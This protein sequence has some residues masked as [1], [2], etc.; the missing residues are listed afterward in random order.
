MTE[1]TLVR[2][3]EAQ[4]REKARTT[5]VEAVGVPELKLPPF[6]GTVE[7]NIERTTVMP[8]QPLETVE[9]GD[10]ANSP[11][12]RFPKGVVLGADGKP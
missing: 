2:R 10:H 1:E 7:R 4:S 6:S 12:K 5:K 3:N 9:S 11:P 8:G